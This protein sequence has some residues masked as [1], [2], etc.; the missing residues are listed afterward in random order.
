MRTTWLAATAALVMG[1]VLSVDA[2]AQYPNQQAYYQPQPSYP[3]PIQ[4]TYQPQLYNNQNQA[5]QFQRFYYYPYYYFDHNYWPVTSPRWPEAP[6]QPYMPPPA[7]MAFPPFHEPN[8]RY[9][10]VQPAKYYRGFHFW[11]DQF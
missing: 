10:A 2:G 7:Y 4:P 9:E 3:L 1:T 5:Y 11:L 6:G 8:W